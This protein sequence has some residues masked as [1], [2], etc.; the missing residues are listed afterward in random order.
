MSSPLI[1]SLIAAVQDRPQDVPL[2]LHLAELLVVAERSPE[3]ITHLAAVLQQDPQNAAAQSL[4]QRAL[5]TTPAPEPPRAPVQMD[6]T[7][8]EEQFAD[9]VPP[10]FARS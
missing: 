2:R 1:E 10:R 8:L 3:A 7:A 9:S 4:M 5:G 6:W